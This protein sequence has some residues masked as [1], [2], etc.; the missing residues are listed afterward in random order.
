MI[1]DVTPSGMMLSNV[2]LICK[3]MAKSDT[4]VVDSVE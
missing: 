1:D 4:R 3:F 2:R